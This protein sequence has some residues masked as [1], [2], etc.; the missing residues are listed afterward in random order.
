MTTRPSVVGRKSLLL[1]RSRDPA[2]HCRVVDG[3]TGSC[4]MTGGCMLFAVCSDHRL[5]G[6]IGRIDRSRT[7]F[8]GGGLLPV[9]LSSGRVRLG[10]LMGWKKTRR[11]D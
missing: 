11:R 3:C 8:G 4:R 1:A 7:L 10:I 2:D 6:C 5:V 9:V